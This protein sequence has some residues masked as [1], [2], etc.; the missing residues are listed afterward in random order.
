MT[1]IGTYKIINTSNNKYYYG[2]SIDVQTR[3]DRHKSD[4]EKNCHH[5]IHLQRAYN[6]YG[7]QSFIYQFDKQYDQKQD[8]HDATIRFGYKI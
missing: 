6:Q 7:K 2:S 3:L 4:L 1:I 8:A 5:C